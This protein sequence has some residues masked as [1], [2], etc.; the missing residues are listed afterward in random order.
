[1]ES[2]KQ[3]SE[4]AFIG[5]NENDFDNTLNEA[6]ALAGMVKKGGYKVV[7]TPKNWDDLLDI[8][9]NKTGNTFYTDD[10]KYAI[11]AYHEQVKIIDLTNALKTGKTC[12][13]YW[14]DDRM[15]DNSIFNA[16]DRN[17][18]LDQILAHF[19]AGTLKDIADPE[20][21]TF[22]FGMYQEKGMTVFSPFA[23][24]NLKRVKKLPS[25]VS[26]SHV[27]KLIANGQFKYLG[28]NYKYTDDYAYDAAT[29]HGKL[30][31][32]NPIDVVER[33]IG[34]KHRS[35]WTQENEAG[36]M[37]ISFGPHSNESW[38]LVVDLSKKL[39]I[40]G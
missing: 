14:M 6:H 30:D 5:F 10:G 9:R 25:R 3:F 23:I 11:K 40:K 38:T 37:V 36:D 39:R 34:F 2:F 12:P 26:I 33:L 21:A 16:F 4:T 13:S 22:T 29:N 35:P 24:G 20:Y 8:I 19:E 18:T 28:R 17:L 31:N 32:V 15:G 1:M 7:K 27:V